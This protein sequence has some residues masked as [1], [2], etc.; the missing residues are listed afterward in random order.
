[1]VDQIVLNYTA[2]AVTPDLDAQ[3]LRLS[4]RPGHLVVAND[5]IAAAVVGKN[6]ATTCVIHDIAKDLIA[7]RTPG[8]P[9]ACAPLRVHPDVTD[10]VVRDD[11][12]RDPVRVVAV[13]SDEMDR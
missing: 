12:I 6:A 5:Q 8:K 4:A 11:A 7:R 10:R 3:L 13:G 9:D 2:V 1:M